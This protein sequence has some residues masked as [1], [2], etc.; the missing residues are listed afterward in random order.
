MNAVQTAPAWNGR[1]RPARESDAARIAA[2]YNES[3]ASSVAT[4]DTQPRSDADQV[5]R[6]RRHGRRY[7]ILVADA[8]G[9]GQVVGWASLTPWSDRPAYAGT[10]EDSVYV[11]R[12]WA[13]RGVGRALLAA[14]IERARAL[15]YHAV[16]ARVA[17]ASPASSSLHSSFGFFEVGVMR[18]V[19]FKFDQW[20]DV[21][22]LELLLDRPAARTAP[23]S[24]GRPRAG[25]RQR[26][27]TTTTRTLTRM[28]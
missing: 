7:P 6:L 16:L 23:A 4:F 22:L 14:T 27:V 12:N 11:D 20:I 28:G 2:I 24:G 10:V 9:D 5:E 21:H 17:G 26:T 8:D 1:I 13:G 18:E 19:G 25:V 3:V 15:G